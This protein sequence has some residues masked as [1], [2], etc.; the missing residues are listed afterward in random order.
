MWKW[1]GVHDVSNN[2]QKENTS[3]VEQIESE[4]PRNETEKKKENKIKDVASNFGSY[5]YTFAD[6][7]AKTAVKLKETV[8]SKLEETIVGDFVRENEK[9]IQQNEDRRIGDAVAPWCGYH[10]EELLKRQI[11]ALS[12]DERNFLRDPPSGVE[13]SFEINH[14]MPTAMATLKEDKELELMRFKLVPKRIKEEKFW[15]NYFY[16][17]SLIKQ[18]TQL[19]TLAD[20]ELKKSPRSSS[21]ESLQNKVLPVKC[22]DQEQEHDHAEYDSANSP[23]NHEFLS[24][25]YDGHDGQCLSEEE[26]SQML[27][28]IKEDVKTDDWDVEKELQEELESFELVNEKGDLNDEDNQQWEK[29]IED[30]LQIGQ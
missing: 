17:V 5:L 10:E 4:E 15:R 7:A 26:K 21:S 6:A 23:V 27:G 20:L 13:Y 14:M 3:S 2:D 28:D 24:D 30:M 29:E 1:L 19:S 22:V 8:D 25:I 9:F 16:R 11:M 18:S 12:S